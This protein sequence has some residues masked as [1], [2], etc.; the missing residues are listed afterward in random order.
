VR[1]YVPTGMIW[2]DLGMTAKVAISL[3]DDIA[4][5]IERARMINGETRSEFFRRAAETRLR[6]ASTPRPVA[7]S[8]GSLR[9][10]LIEGP[11]PDTG[12]AAD[13][14]DARRRLGELPSDPWER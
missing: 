1:R 14:E 10:L 8:W 2:Y 11:Q 4:T 6:G 3:P 5:A 9:G 12:L 7:T 13:V